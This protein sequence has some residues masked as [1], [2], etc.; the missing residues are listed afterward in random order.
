MTHSRYTP[1]RLHRCT[2]PRLSDSPCDAVPIAGFPSRAPSRSTSSP[3][4]GFR[5]PRFESPL[6][7]TQ[8]SA[9]RIPAVPCAACERPF[10]DSRALCPLLPTVPCHGNAAVA[11]MMRSRHPAPHR[12]AHA[13]FARDPCHAPSSASI[14]LRYC[15]LLA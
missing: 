3:G 15:L 5:A 11:P 6:R 8:P 12:H 4:L 13:A 1:A 9:S 7:S 2:C 10:L 14:F